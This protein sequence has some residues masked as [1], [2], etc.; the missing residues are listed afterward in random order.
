MATIRID[1]LAQLTTLNSNT[2][3]TI[4]PVVDTTTGDT[5]QINIGILGSQLFLNQPLIANANVIFGDS[6]IQHTASSPASYSQASFALANTNA[7]GLIYVAGVNNTQNNI[8]QTVYNLANTNANNIINVNNFVQSSYNTANGALQRTGGIVTGQ[9]N[10]NNYTIISNSF[11]N[12][13]S[14]T[15]LVQILGSANSSYQMPSNPGYMLQVVGLDGTSSRIINDSFGTNTY[16]LF[17]GRKGN[18]TAGNPLNVANNDVIFRL[19]GNGY[20]NG[21]SQFGQARIDFVASENFSSTNQG[22]QIQFW[23]TIP[24]TNNLTQIATFNANTVSFTGEVIPQK[25]FRYTPNVINGQT[26]TLTI[27]FT[28]DSLIKA[29]GSSGLTVSLTNFEAGKEVILWFVSTAGATTTV[30]HGALANNSTINSASF[31]MPAQSTAYLRYF[32]IDGS[33]SN[34]FVNISHA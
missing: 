3:N 20:A 19:S 34:T 26:S 7:N 23:N 25:G 29:N 17:A 33:L 15:P 31:S 13:N 24:G 27:D 16:S 4:I 9:L 1:Q 21:F 5:N 22:T 8:T 11:F 14:N 32:S 2:S 6:T 18:G 10:V 12:I 28:R 30:T